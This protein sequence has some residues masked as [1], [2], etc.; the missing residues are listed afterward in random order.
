M[1]GPFFLR[2]HGMVAEPAAT[3]GPGASTRAKVTAEMPTL[4]WEGSSYEFAGES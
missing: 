2:V 1:L 3:F 4:G